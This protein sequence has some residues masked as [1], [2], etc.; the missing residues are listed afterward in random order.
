MEKSE[1]VFVVGNLPALGSW[2]HYQAVQLHQE[3]AGAGDPST[4]VVFEG[5]SSKLDCPVD[6][7]SSPLFRDYDHDNTDD[8]LNNE[9]E[10]NK[11]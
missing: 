11:A 5:N 2:S 1:S 10:A 9:N 7:D 6:G 3:H 4:A 8:E